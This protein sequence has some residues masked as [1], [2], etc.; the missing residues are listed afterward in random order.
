MRK[1]IVKRIIS[2]VLLICMVLSVSVFAAPAK[3]ST[4]NFRVRIVDKD[5]VPI[6]NAP[7]A[8]F[9]KGETYNDNNYTI[10]TED[11]TDSKGEF[12][13]KSINPGTYNLNLTTKAKDDKYVVRIE[14]EQIQ[15]TVNAKNTKDTFVVKAKSKNFNKVFYDAKV[16]TDIYVKNS[17]GGP[18]SN[19][20]LELTSQTPPQTYGA[21]YGMH[22]FYPIG[23]TDKDGRV[24]FVGFANV[25]YS[26]QFSWLGGKAKCDKTVTFSKDKVNTYTLTFDE[27][28]LTKTKAK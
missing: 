12:R 6:A 22:G 27:T 9:D 21:P 10:H 8:V 11:M 4:L 13:I 2:S 25:D 24:T 7:V 3:V 20:K 16:R 5:G 17:K 14:D 28:L 18:V 26:V 1:T 19:M 23:F 15:I